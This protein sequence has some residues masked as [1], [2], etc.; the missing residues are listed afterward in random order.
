M[1]LKDLAD[2]SM[3]DVEVGDADYIV[4]TIEYWDNEKAHNQFTVPETS[5]RPRPSPPDAMLVP[6][7]IIGPV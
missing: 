3:S 4:R 5:D 2:D 1:L 7:S 6:F